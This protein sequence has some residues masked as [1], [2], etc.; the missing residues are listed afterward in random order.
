MLKPHHLFR[1][2]VILLA[3]LLC[4][5]SLLAQ[6]DKKAAPAYV[7]LGSGHLDEAISQARAAIASNIN[8]PFHHNVLCRAYYAENLADSAITE[9][10]AALGAESANSEYALWLGRAYGMKAEQTTLTAFSWAKR[11]RTMFAHAVELDGNNADAINDLAQFYVDAPG[12][13]GGSL[14][15]ADALVPKMQPLSRARPS[16]PRPDSRQARRLWHR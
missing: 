8:P 2:A 6:A 7:S 12:I 9:C 13:V 15:K 3:L 1:S 11:A 5:V 16:P 10:E 4:S 14:D